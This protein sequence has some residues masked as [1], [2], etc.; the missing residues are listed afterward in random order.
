MVCM[1]MVECTS[2]VSMVRVDNYTKEKYASLKRECSS[3]FVNFHSRL[4]NAVALSIQS[5]S[6]IAHSSSIKGYSKQVNGFP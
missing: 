5:K 1:G 2:M 6:T 3:F 4:T